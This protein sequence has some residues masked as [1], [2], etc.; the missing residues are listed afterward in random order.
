MGRALA[1]AGGPAEFADESRIFVMRQ[2]PA[3]R[4]IRFTY[5]ALVHNEAGAATFGELSDLLGE[6]DLFPGSPPERDPSRH[7]RRWAFE[8]AALD[9]ALRLLDAV[10]VPD[11][12]SP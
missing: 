2:H 11:G 7:Y 8:S 9:L 12:Q 5:D 1:Q 4:R 10:D 6:L 3:F